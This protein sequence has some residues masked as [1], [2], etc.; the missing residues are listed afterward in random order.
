MAARKRRVGRAARSK[1]AGAAAH[2]RHFIRYAE[3][4]EPIALEP[5]PFAKDL[6]RMRDRATEVKAL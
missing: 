1:S 5:V 6:K 2:Y 3:T 4:V